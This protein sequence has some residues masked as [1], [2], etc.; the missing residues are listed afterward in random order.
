MLMG[1]TLNMNKYAAKIPNTNV[2]MLF[3]PDPVYC[4]SQS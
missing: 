2:G 1:K 3:D 4:T